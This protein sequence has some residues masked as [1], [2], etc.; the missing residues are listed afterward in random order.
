[1]PL[2]TQLE[3]L[4]K[5]KQNSFSVQTGGFR[6]TCMMS[7]FFMLSFKLVFNQQHEYSNLRK[8][9][10]W[11]LFLSADKN[12]VMKSKMSTHALYLTYVAEHGL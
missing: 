6:V 10:A 4:S 5:W 3:W 11:E 9:I 8:Y 12:E 1:M 2:G 7:L